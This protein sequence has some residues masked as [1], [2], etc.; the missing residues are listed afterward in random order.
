[1]CPK[2]NEEAKSSIFKENGEEKK[3]EEFIIFL[4]T[5]GQVMFIV[6]ALGGSNTTQNPLFFIYRGSRHCK[7]LWCFY[8]IPQNL[9]VYGIN[10]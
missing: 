6:V 7:T 4:S 10:A 9:Q 2:N 8:S 1:L 3:T 5:M